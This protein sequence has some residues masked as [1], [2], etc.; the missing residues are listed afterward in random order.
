MSYYGG[1]TVYLLNA[2][3]SSPTYHRYGR[4]DRERD[5][6]VST[7]GVSLWQLHGRSGISLPRRHADKFARPCRK[8]F[9]AG[10]EAARPED[11]A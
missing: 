7:C 8:C 11:A 4:I 6:E 3:L 9:P 10:S 1:E 2:Y 5:E